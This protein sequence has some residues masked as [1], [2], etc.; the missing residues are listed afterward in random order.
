MGLVVII[1]VFVCVALIVIILLQAG[2]GADMGAAFGGTTQ[3]LFGPTGPTPFLGKVTVGAAIIF[4]IT[5]ITLS[6]FSRKLP[7]ETIFKEKAP[8]EQPVEESQPAAPT[9][10]DT[11]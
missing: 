11:R 2:R 4:M 1:H 6:Y 10:H 3:T 9:A 5:S 8:V 7:R